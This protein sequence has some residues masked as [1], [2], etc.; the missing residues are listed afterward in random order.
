VLLARE[1]VESIKLPNRLEGI[2]DTDFD[3][4]FYCFPDI[5]SRAVPESGDE[6][7]LASSELQNVVQKF[8]RRNCAF[9][10]N[11][12]ASQFDGFPSRLVPIFRN[13]LHNGMKR[14]L[15]ISHRIAIIGKWE[16]NPS[17]PGKGIFQFHQRNG[18]ASLIGFREKVL[19]YVPVGVTKD[20]GPRGGV[21]NAASILRGDPLVP[22]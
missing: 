17:P 3:T 10:D 16:G 18:N 19:R 6:L 8:L 1:A 22:A 4:L 7:G 12:P 9:G 13:R 2:F 15:P 21:E 5:S 11:F 14:R 20:L